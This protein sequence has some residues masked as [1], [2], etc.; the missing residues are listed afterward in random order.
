MNLVRLI[1]CLIATVACA[2]CSNH[3]RESKSG[4]TITDMQ[5]VIAEMEQAQAQSQGSG[6]LAE[7]LA[8]KD[9]PDASIYY[10]DAPSPIGMVPNVLGFFN[11]EWLGLGDLGYNDIKAARVLFFDA[12]QTDG[13]RKTALIIGIKS[14]SDQFT[15]YAFTGTDADIADHSYQASLGNG[16]GTG[17]IIVKTVDVSGGSLDTVIQL[18]V[19]SS[20]GAYLGKISTLVGFKN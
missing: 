13:T 3:W 1:T 19:Y 12:P 8:L 11:F 15:Y 16:S 9:D 18:K 2:A 17:D 4:L 20:S 7:A 14:T 5:N 6:N 10:S